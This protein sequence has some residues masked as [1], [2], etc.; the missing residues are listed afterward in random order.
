MDN[1]ANV[2][3]DGAANAV[4]EEQSEALD[5][6]FDDLDNTG[7]KIGGYA[8]FTQNDPRI[9]Q[10]QYRD[11]ILLLQIDSQRPAILWGDVGVGK[12][13][14]HPDALARKDFS[15]VLYNWDCSE[16]PPFYRP[17]LC[18]AMERK[19]RKIFVL[20]SLF[21]RRKAPSGVSF[22]TAAIVLLL[23]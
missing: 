14:I 5:A 21:M 9:M 18:C 12:F 7:H 8:Y 3:E 20:H 1:A 22:R 15:E 6:A 11:R 23:F 13:F 19:A 16:A 2:S 10:A 17:V 4:A